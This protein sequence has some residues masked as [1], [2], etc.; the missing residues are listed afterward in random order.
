VLESCRTDKISGQKKKKR[1]RK[2]AISEKSGGVSQN[3]ATA[4]DPDEK[5][6]GVS[7]NFATAV[8]P[9][10]MSLEGKKKAPGI[11]GPVGA[12]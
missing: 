8:D 6:G 12:R 3:F 10:S 7:Q 4:V 1:H 9:E 5:S 11:R 2:V